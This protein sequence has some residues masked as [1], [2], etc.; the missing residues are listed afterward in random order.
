MK[1]KNRY[2]IR[3]TRYLIDSKRSKFKKVTLVFLGTYLF[4]SYG[5][6]E[7]GRYPV[8]RPELNSLLN[9]IFYRG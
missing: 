2:L 1:G 9:V 7:R 8:K 4:L 6:F 3:S 5:I